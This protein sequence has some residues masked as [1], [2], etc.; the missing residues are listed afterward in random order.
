MATLQQFLS[1]NNI[2]VTTKFVSRVYHL[3]DFKSDNYENKPK[4]HFEGIIT[5]G[6]N[7]LTV[8]Y[9]KGCGYCFSDGDR[10]MQKIYQGYGISASQLILDEIRLGHLPKTLGINDD[11]VHT[12]SITD[13]IIAVINDITFCRDYRLSEYIADFSDHDAVSIENAI[14]GYH[15]MQKYENFFVANLGYKSMGELI[16]IVHELDN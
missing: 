4:L 10:N 11:R 9:T 7:S 6:G 3:S 5:I 15:T 16:E 13:L 12:L 8:P 2:T 14:N 1:N